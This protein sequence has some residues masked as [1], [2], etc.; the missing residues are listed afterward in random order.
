MKL[1]VVTLFSITFLASRIRLNSE[2]KKRQKKRRKV[3][4]LSNGAQLLLYAAAAVVKL[5]A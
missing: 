5:S 4:S 1:V 2:I 3:L